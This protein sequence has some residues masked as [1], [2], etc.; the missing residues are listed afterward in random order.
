L[1]HE[2][3]ERGI[4]FHGT[5]LVMSLAVTERV[6]KHRK[7]L[8]A[9]GLKPVQIWLPD[10]HLQSFRQQCEGECLSLVDDPHEVE[11][12]AWIAEAADTDGWV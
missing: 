10:T 8:R 1:L 11:T 6:R 5:E 4:L 12:L 7:V 2:T 3:E 9:A